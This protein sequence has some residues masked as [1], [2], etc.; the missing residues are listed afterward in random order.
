MDPQNTT[1]QAQGYPGQ[2]PQ[3]QH[4][5]VVA[6]PAQLAPQ[7][8]VVPTLPPTVPVHPVAQQN[9]PGVPPA[10]QPDSSSQMQHVAAP[11]EAADGDVIE[12]D[13]VVKAKQIVGDTRH[14]PYKQVRE[15]NKL[16][17]EYM[18]KRYDKEL[19]LPEA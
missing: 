5:G 11:A 17:A 16:K 14:D 2:T 15:L 9:A 4:A 7:P 13:W 6:A 1:D 12:K 3:P 18:K 8:A 19:K 10:E